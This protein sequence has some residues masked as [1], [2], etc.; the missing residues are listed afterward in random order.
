MLACFSILACRQSEHAQGPQ[1]LVSTEAPGPCLT[2]MGPLPVVAGQ[3]MRY[4]D[5]SSLAVSDA[6]GSH[7]WQSGVAELEFAWCNKDLLCI[8]MAS[9]VILLRRLPC[10]K[11]SAS[12]RTV[13]S[14]ACIGNHTIPETLM[15]EV[16]LQG[17]P[18]TEMRRTENH[19][20]T[21][22]THTETVVGTEPGVAARHAADITIRYSHPQDYVLTF[23][24]SACASHM[25][26]VLGARG[27]HVCSCRAGS[28]SSSAGPF[29]CSV[30]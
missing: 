7:M 12:K 2:G 18:T 1:L 26:L 23:V 27:R 21:E 6:V 28:Q 4:S 22:V 20:L 9:Y 29:Y 3:C 25:Q 17:T 13:L 30:G 8:E 11:L 24:S 10:T 19:P 5:C 14:C 15:Q 16:H